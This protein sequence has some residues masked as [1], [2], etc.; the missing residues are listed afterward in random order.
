[1][2]AAAYGNPGIDTRWATVAVVVGSGVVTALQVGKA[3]IAAPM[4]QSDLGLDLA[5]AG[6]LTGIFAVLGLV[7]SIPAG[8][9]VTATG[10]RRMLMVGLGTIALGTVIGAAAPGYSVL[11]AS[12]VLEGFGFLLVTVAGPA[13]LH[14]VVRSGQRDL[15]F[16]LWSCFMPAGMALAMLAGPLFSDWRMLW[17]CNAGLAAAAITAGV[18]LIPAYPVHQ[19]ISWRSLAADIMRVLTS[20]G[21]VLLAVSFALYSMM[22][23]ALFSFLP[24]LLMQRMGID[25][26][27]AGLLSALACAA[28]VIGN[29]A[30]SNLLARGASRSA[31]IAGACLIMGLVSPGIFL[32]IFADLCR[33]TNVPAV[34][35]VLRHWRD[36]P[37][38]SHL[39]SAASGIVPGACPRGHRLGDAGQQSRSGD[40]SYRCWWCNSNLRL[41]SRRRNRLDCGNDRRHCRPRHQIR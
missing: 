14:R 2:T 6:W 12:R 13:I 20:V 3:A 5:A 27:T 1:M 18:A 10:D 7:G 22:F 31:L 40:R 16:A 36:D 29:L 23:F 25:H 24:V 30:A 9:F 33:Y 21:P 37:G 39:V 28:N 32:P 34:H 38:Y 41:D 8:A 35:P 11:L 19:S 4:L 26:G 17:W 15:A